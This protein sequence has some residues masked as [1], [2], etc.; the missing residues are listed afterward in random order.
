VAHAPTRAEAADSLA[1]ALD[2]LV[3]LG[4]PTNSDYLARV[5]RH[6]QFLA[7]KLHT[8][9]LAKHAR[10]LTGPDKPEERAVAVLTALLTD[11]EFH[12]AALSAPEPHATIGS[13]RN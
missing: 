13:W 6:P 10:E 7:G 4:V 5:L 11:Q 12:R 9:F 2:A 3:L 8:G 1:R